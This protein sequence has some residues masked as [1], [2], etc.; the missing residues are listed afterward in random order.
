MG[1]VSCDEDHYNPV[2]PRLLSAFLKGWNPGA[3]T[4]ERGQSQSVIRGGGGA[5]GVHDS[6]GDGETGI[7]PP[8]FVVKTDIYSSGKN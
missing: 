2:G 5:K 3:I 6:K 7:R 1:G 8:P 4:A